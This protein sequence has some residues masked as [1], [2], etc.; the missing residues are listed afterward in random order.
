MGRG[1][2]DS[3]ETKAGEVFFA[4]AGGPLENACEHVCQ[5][6]QIGGIPK[7][8]RATPN[9]KRPQT[10]AVSQGRKKTASASIKKQLK[11]LPSLRAFFK[12]QE[13][14]PETPVMPQPPSDLGEGSGWSKEDNNCRSEM[15][16]T[17]LALNPY[18]CLVEIGGEEHD[19]NV[20]NPTTTGT[21]E[22][23]RL[24]TRDAGSHQESPG[25]EGNGNLYPQKFLRSQGTYMDD[26][27]TQGPQAS[28]LEQLL[29]SPAKQVRNVF[30]VSQANQ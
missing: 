12:A 2:A 5:G 22:A 25:G 27:R 1:V 19:K 6:D 8:V 17:P 4:R 30:P 10:Q 26:D 29:Q 13:R 18:R 14:L 11:I 24:S 21:A 23:Q 7:R 28:S 9:Q 15:G 20:E 3:Q 16:P